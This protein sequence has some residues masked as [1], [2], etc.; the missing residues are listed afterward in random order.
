MS[1]ETA[2]MSTKDAVA[3]IYEG[4]PK[5]F[6]SIEGKLDSLERGIEEIKQRLDRHDQR[7]DTIEQEMKHLRGEITTLYCVVN[8]LGKLIPEL[9]AKLRESDTVED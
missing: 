7:F 5:R 6:D 8:P 9:L 1:L 3:A 2:Q 4:H